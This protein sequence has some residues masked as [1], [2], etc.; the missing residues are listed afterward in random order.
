MDKFEVPA[1]LEI[2]PDEFLST[3]EVVKQPELL[4][5]AVKLAIKELDEWHYRY[6]NFFDYLLSIQAWRGLPEQLGA[7]ITVGHAINDLLKTLGDP[8]REGRS[9]ERGGD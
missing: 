5:Q 6:R 4:E 1:F 3:E 7:L 8:E 2:R 9:D